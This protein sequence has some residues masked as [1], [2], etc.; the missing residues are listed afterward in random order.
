MSKKLL[1]VESPTKAKKL[2]S[3]LDDSY[4]IEASFGHFL[5]LPDDE[6]GFNLDTFEEKFVPLKN[7]GSLDY[8]G[9]IRKLKDY[10]E[11]A[12][13]VIIASDPDR[14]GEAIGWHLMKTL[15]CKN[16]YDRIEIHEITVKGIKNALAKRRNIDLD[17]VESQR[18]RR[19]LDRMLG[20]GISP[21]L[22]KNIEN[23]KSA[24][25]VQSSALRLICERDQEN[26]RH[27]PEPRYE[28]KAT[29]N[30]SSDFEASLYLNK[31][32]QSK[33]QSTI[34]DENEENNQESQVHEKKLISNQEL[35]SLLSE[36]KLINKWNVTNI[37]HKEVLIKPDAPFITSTLQ[38]KASSVLG[39]GGDVT[40]KHAQSLFDNGHITYHRTD[41]T[42]IA[43]EA[44]TEAFEY[45]EKKY[46]KDYIPETPNQYKNKDATQD[47][48]EA[49][50]PTHLDSTP[51][52]LSIEEQKLYD[53]ICERFI[54]SQA[55]AGKNSNQKTKIED[56][57]N[58]YLFI[59]NT[60]TL[61]FDGWRKIA[62]TTHAEKLI[63]IQKGN[64]LLK[65]AIQHQY[66][67]KA[68]PRFKEHTLIKEMEKNGVG[69]PS[70]YASIVKTLKNRTYIKIDNDKNI[71]STDL[72]RKV[73][74]WLMSRAPH[75]TDLKY[76]AE[77]EDRLDKIAH[78]KDKRF[79]VLKEVRDDLIDIF[80]AFTK[81]G[82]MKPSFK[83]VNI[84]NQ[85]KDS[86]I[87]IPDEA[88]ED[89]NTAKPFIDDFFNNRRPSEK[90]VNFAK[91]IAEQQGL[92]L[93]DN[94]LNS[95]KLL[96]EFIDKNIKNSPKK[97]IPATEK[98]IAMATKLSQ[99]TGIEY[100]DDYKSSIA[101]TSDFISK[102]LKKANKK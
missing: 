23:G 35:T 99:E 75:Y 37:E 92:H 48:H 66:M 16:N 44:Q 36:I 95:G 29:F 73:N 45:I 74:N 69:R 102:A 76:T 85:I 94:V 46:G 49:I 72:G 8:K 11:H 53:L 100:P 81:G 57:N 18:T 40:M 84:L 58:Q 34:E 3:I 4:Q 67:T 10:A 56:D 13:K 50:R 24:G 101:K 38:Q 17:M 55:I 93:D 1:I 54:C 88:F 77:M 51:N 26:E 30:Q 33:V 15:N 21:V 80:N 20:Y 61:I 62:K 59:N 31:Y 65:N 78:G 96:S 28:I 14:E 22:Q 87:N 64:A 83:Q 43:E 7:K 27:K 63:N 12:S 68:K 70:S 19:L 89:M 98:Q 5:D 97:E 52:D 79:D 86:G 42:R 2:R 6:L 41:S 90:Q 91:Q 60:S 25:R 71:I 82:S 39:W 47:A 32:I 9:I